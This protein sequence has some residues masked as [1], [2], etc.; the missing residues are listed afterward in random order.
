MTSSGATGD[1]EPAHPPP[2]SLDSL[3]MAFPSADQACK[4]CRRRKAKCNRAIPTCNLC[5]KYRRHCL[6]EKHARTP[7]TRKHLTEVEERLERAEAIITQMRALMPA[8]LRSGSV[9]PSPRNLET[10]ALRSD[11]ETFDFSKLDTPAPSNPAPLPASLPVLTANGP[12]ALPQCEAAHPEPSQPFQPSQIPQNHVSSSVPPS[13]NMRFEPPRASRTA[14]Y[15][16]HTDTSHRDLNLL[17]AHPTDDFEWDEQE[18]LTNY[19][20]SPEAILEADLNGEVIADPIADGMASLAVSERESGYL[21]V[22]SGAALLRLLEPSTPRRRTQSSSSRPGIGVGPQQQQQQQHIINHLQNPLIAQQPDPNRHITDA[23]IDAYFRLYHVSYPIIHEATF[24]AQYAGVIPRPSGDCWLV[25]AYTVA[26]IGVY[27]T[28]ANLDNLDTSLFAQARSILSFNFLEVGNL[29]LV[30]ALTLI[31]NYQQKRDKPNSGYNYLGLAVRMAMGLGLHKEFQ[32]WNISPLNM[33]IRRRVWWSLC[34]FDVGATITF[35]RPSVWPYEGVEVSL[36][37]NVDDKSLTAISK[38]YPPETDGITPYTAVR[39]QAS[40]HIATTPIYTRVISKPLPSPDEML[41]LDEDLLDPWLASVPSYF[42][43]TSRVPP[44]YALA[45]AVM[46]WRYRNLRIIMYRPFVIRRALRARDRRPDD[47]PDNVRAFE[48]CLAEAK[49]TITSISEFWQR[50]EHNR[51]GA[52]YALYFLFQAALIPCICLRNDPAS[53]NARD[54]QEQ[55]TT[56]TRCIAALAPVNSSS[57][58]CYQ[59]IID[60]CGRF[61]DSNDIALPVAPS[62]TAPADS[63]TSPSYEDNAAQPSAPE[64][65]D[66]SPQ[67]QINSVFSM[68]W[69]NVPPLE[70]ADVVMGDDAW[71]E[72]LKGGTSGDGDGMWFGS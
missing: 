6:Y 62:A 72:F 54:W 47:S 40:F 50:N 10:P 4:E 16:P 18:T 43:S 55:I 35:S 8:Q 3:S 39:T 11:D 63:T 56:T 14:Q 27:T 24:R 53:P 38:S 29:T 26:A 51:L 37:L 28:A 61:L 45:H 5:V 41:R 23:M 12:D 15:K 33:E 71:M 46:N 22:A 68:M 66:E 7:L 42:S 19:S 64:P 49:A 70:A 32:G 65:I 60:L 13:S 1:N 9:L 25:L 17:E 21:G 58:R 20:A 57:S 30:Q 67:T 34:V 59:V 2:S 69:P 48:K 52:W 31:S 44:K 36:P